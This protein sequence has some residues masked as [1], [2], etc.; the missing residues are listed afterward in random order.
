M[1]RMMNNAL[2]GA[3]LS[4]L[5][6]PGLGQIKLKH[7]RRGIVLMLMVLV[8]FAVIVAKAVQQAL[9]LLRS[10][11]LNGGSVDI[12]AIVNAATLASTDSSS[13]ISTIA[14]LWVGAFWI[15]GALDAYRIGKGRDKNQKS[16]HRAHDGRFHLLSI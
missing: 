3:L 11:D 7:L 14:W 15:I 4:G 2:R 13:I 9:A 8:G 1:E 10:I 12:E 16:A 5:V 6:F